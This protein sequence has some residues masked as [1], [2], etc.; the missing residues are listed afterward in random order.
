MHIG[1]V[2]FAV[3]DPNTDLE[4]ALKSLGCT[5]VIL[6]YTDDWFDIIRRSRIKR[7]VF[8]GSALDVLDKKSP[9]L[10][11]RLLDLSNKRLLFICYSMESILMQLGCK[12]HNR[13]VSKTDNIVI[14]DRDIDMTV[15]RNHFAYVD[16]RSVPTRIR[17]LSK[18]KNDVMTA[19]Y[20][21]SVMTQWHPEKTRDGIEFIKRWL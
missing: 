16:A 11:I 10:D 14:R 12:L 1:I 6:Q 4:D 2:N 8:T 5:V 13:R 3:D 20:K 7:W 15:A 19:E 18:Y 9:Q 17:L 21:N